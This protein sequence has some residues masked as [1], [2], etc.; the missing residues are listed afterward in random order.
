MQQHPSTLC[1]VGIIS[2]I[3][4]VWLPLTDL[5]AH[6]PPHIAPLVKQTIIEKKKTLAHVYHHV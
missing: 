3:Q 1:S 5:S 6:E 4:T 2:I